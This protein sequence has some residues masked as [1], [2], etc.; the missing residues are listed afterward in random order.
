[1]ATTFDVLYLGNAVDLDQDEAGTNSGNAAALNGLTYGDAGQP[2]SS[3]VRSWAPGSTGAAAGSSS[4]DYDANNG[5]VSDTFTIDGGPDLIV[6]AVVIYNATVTY[7]DGTTDTLRINV[8]QDSN[9]D[10]YL[11]PQ[12]TFD[13]D[14]AKLEAG[15]IRSLT[16]DS[17]HDQTSTMS[18]DRYDANFAEFTA[19]V[20]ST[21]G[22]DGTNSGEEMGV[23]FTDGDGDQIT[24]SADVIHGNGGDDTIYA[25]GGSDA[26]YGGSGSDVIYGDAGDTATASGAPAPVGPG[27]T[28]AGIDRVGGVVSDGEWDFSTDAFYLGND[29][30]SME[31][32]AR[33]YLDNTTF[34]QDGTST[35]RSVS[36]TEI[37]FTGAQK[38]VYGYVT[39]Q[40]SAVSGANDTMQALDDPAPLDI[41]TINPTYVTFIMNDGT[42]FTDIQMTLVRSSDGDT[43]MIPTDT[44]GTGKFRETVY[45]NDSGIE[46]FEI[47]FSS[48][49]NNGFSPV[50]GDWADG[51]FPPPEGGDDTI[52]GG[53]GDDTIYGET[54]HDSIDGG[55][56][57]DV[58]DGGEGADSLFGGAGDDRF[59][60]DD[61][62]SALSARAGGSYDDFDGHVEA[63]NTYTTG[64]QSP[65]KIV[66]L[67]D[68]KTMYIWI[69]DAVT[70]GSTNAEIQ[71]RLYNADGNPATDQISLNALAAVDGYDGFDWDSLDVDMLPDGNVVISYVISGGDAGSGAER[72]VFAIVEPTDTGVNIVQGT[73]TIPEID[74]STYQSP[75]VT[76]V[77]DNGNIMFV[78]SENATGDATNMDLFGRIYDPD[79]GTFT[80][81]FPVGDVSVDGTNTADVP[82]MEIVQLENGNIVVTYVRNAGEVGGNEPVFTILDSAGNTVVP[83]TEFQATDTTTYESPAQIV[84]MDDGNFMGIWINNGYSD[85][86]NTMQLEGRIFDANGTPLTGDIDLTGDGYSVDGWN[87]YDI[88]NFTID[89]L[90]STHIVVS[91][92]NGTVNSGTGTADDPHFTIL[93]ISD[94]ANPVITAQDVPIAVSPDHA[95]TGP[96][97]IE[98]LGDSGYFVAVYGDGNAA[99]GGAYGLNYRVFDVNGNPL[100]GDMQL[101]ANDGSADTVSGLD[102]FDWA[103]VDVEY[104]AVE[105]DFTVTW[106]GTSDGSNTGVYT[107]GPID[108]STLTGDGLGQE[109]VVGGEAGE[110]EGDLLD[111]GAV[112]DGLGVTFDTTESG[113]VVE[114]PSGQE[115][116]FSEI[117]R[118]IT[119]AGDDTVDG[120]LAT[121]NLDI[122]AGDGSD[123][124]TGGQGNDLL[125]GGAGN[126][127]IAGGAGDDTLIGG[128]GADALDGGGGVD[129]ADYSASDAGVNVNLETSTFSGGHAQGDSGSNLEN[130]IGSDFDDTL[131][132]MDEPGFGQDNV[133][134]GGAGDDFISGLA[135]DDTLLGGAGD[136]TI[137]GGAGADILTGGDGA[138]VFIADGTADTITDFDTS[139]GID[140]GVSDDNDFVDLTGF[141]NDDNLA[142]WNAANP[143]QTYKTPLQWMRADQADGSLGEAGNLRIER[144]GSPVDPFELNAE[145]TGV[146]CFAGG[147]LIRVP[148]GDVPV[149][150][151]RR[152]DLVQTRDNGVKPIL[153]IGRRT[154]SEAELAAAPNLRP[155]RLAAGHFGLARDLVVSPQHGVLLRDPNCGNSDILW[156]AR[157][158]SKMEG[159]AARIMQGCKQVTYYHILFDQHELVFSNGIPSESFYPGPM[160]YQALSFGAQTELITLFPDLAH[161]PAE[162]AFGP[163]ARA[164]SRNKILPKHLSA[165][166][167]AH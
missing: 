82:N 151:L 137:D 60:F 158:L 72:P 152:G 103:N 141:Y 145:N 66:T 64:Y 105:G 43:F 117:E 140:G 42:V 13:A 112:T 15:P 57:D 133:V 138:D 32:A 26:I 143:A 54:G 113:T 20:D 124:V 84:A 67:A 71:T 100:T 126:D 90:D 110:T 80:S 108:V 131:V 106:V 18:P 89:T 19:G 99:S 12:E 58:I 95:Y 83:V 122:E 78:W 50:S 85:D 161:W 9:G 118:L 132:G 154:L 130:I 70:D 1:M 125:S 102:N 47:Q 23:G 59:I 107:S 65:P 116:H 51:M 94:P 30:P 3:N 111:L 146:V 101:T 88:P 155:V 8:I 62:D 148:G 56:G 129:V 28:G 44:T 157:H 153:W 21:D 134:D 123:I 7:M 135:G 16:I 91:Y 49:D 46:S 73:T 75:P 68:G 52:H 119:G 104:N 39:V 48:G 97:L 5:T 115:L 29:I 10:L 38:N 120:S 27:S 142:A 98:P 128:A 166:Q 93:D 25:G 61:I 149:E 33:T 74:G 4:S 69:N 109:Y 121:G 41:Q 6:D 163:S 96:A 147:T 76:T 53:D 79:A 14:Q 36:L 164:Y 22:I 167:S 114:D 45:N 37:D 63:L 136:D 81:Q 77:L 92:V 162:E 55:D 150:M 87:S 139:T 165:L 86:T 11:L 24:N 2:L 31:G 159:G 127:T 34:S 160:A 17:V 35:D 156:R 144:A 40:R